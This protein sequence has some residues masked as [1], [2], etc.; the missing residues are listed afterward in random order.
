MVAIY[1]ICKLPSDDD[2]WMIAYEL[3]F[4]NIRPKRYVPEP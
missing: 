4:Y 1:A 2:L 3:T